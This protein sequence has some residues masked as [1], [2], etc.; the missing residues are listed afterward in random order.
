[1]AW[2]AHPSAQELSFVA[3]RSRERVESA[4][5]ARMNPASTSPISGAPAPSALRTI[6]T[7]GLIA[8]VLDIT[9]VLVYFHNPAADQLRVFKGIAAGLLGPSAA[10]GDWPIALLGAAIHF[11]IALTW[12]AV[13]F[14]LSRKFPVLLRHWIVA[15]A[16]FGVVVWLVMNLVVLPRD[17]NPPAAFPPPRWVPVFVAHLLCIG[18]PIAFITRRLAGRSETGA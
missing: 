5:N 3:F 17:A 18:W 13:F 9:Y 4:S 8:G 16:A 2:K 12:A 1:V 14:A 15:G 11:A 10:K 6:L 7:A